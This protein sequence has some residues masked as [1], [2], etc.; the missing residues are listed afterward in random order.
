MYTGN[1]SN[2]ANIGAPPPNR[3]AKDLRSQRFGRLYVFS[4]HST[5]PEGSVLWE[6]ICDC[7]GKKIASTKLL[8]RGEITTC[9]CG[10]SK[11]H[12]MSKTKFYKNWVS[13]LQRCNNP[14]FPHFKHYGGRGIKVCE[15]WLRFET[16]Y[17]EMFPTYKSGLTIDRK[18]V[19]G[20][21]SFENC[22]WAT[23]KEQQ[24][25]KRNTI[26]LTIHSQTGTI[27]EWSKISGTLAQTIT[28]RYFRG[29]SHDECV[30][31][32]KIDQHN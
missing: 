27:D 29:W 13:M 20:E 7:G 14:K 25:N 3:R 23:R 9:G 1:Q 28:T 18:N 21:Y 22:Q 4:Y 8:N 16:F 2:V 12:G 5:G 10:S 6:C 19:N 15:A 24:L 32:K 30:Y 31:G 26:R 17:K 11:T